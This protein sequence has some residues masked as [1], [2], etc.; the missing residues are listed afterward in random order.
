MRIDSAIRCRMSEPTQANSFKL[1]SAEY[2]VAGSTSAWE[3][4]PP[5]LLRIFHKQVSVFVLGQGVTIA[6]CDSATAVGESTPKLANL[7]TNV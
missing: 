4:N 2:A 7:K 6:V 5:Q 1:S 3:I